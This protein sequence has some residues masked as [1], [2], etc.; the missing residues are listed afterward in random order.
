MAKVRNKLPLTVE[1]KG[2]PRREHYLDHLVKKNNW[3]IGV[4]VGVRFG[5]TLFHL[6]D[7]NPNLKMYAVDKDITQFD[8]PGVREKY[9]SRL[10]I[11]DGVSW[12]QHV[13]I[14]EAIDFVF[15]DAG[16][17]TKDVIKDVEAYRPLLKTDQ[18]LTGHDVD[19]PAIQQA[20]KQLNIKYDVCPDNVWTTI[21]I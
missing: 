18:G 16:H 9:G 17:G 21:K 4:E 2:P 20:L 8:K 19:F 12:Q 6:L 5:R 3:N 7:N 15:I 1:W 11:L 13:H 14:K 10:V